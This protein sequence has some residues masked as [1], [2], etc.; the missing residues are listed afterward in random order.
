MAYTKQ[1]TA[2]LKV[3]KTMEQPAMVLQDSI[4]AQL[5]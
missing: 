3:E 2:T 1:D 4:T 5:A